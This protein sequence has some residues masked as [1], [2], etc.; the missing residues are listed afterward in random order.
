MYEG[1][2]DLSLALKCLNT[3]ISLN[4][5][6]YEAITEKGSALYLIRAK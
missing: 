4:K 1:K 5:N 6:N 3:A 2:Y